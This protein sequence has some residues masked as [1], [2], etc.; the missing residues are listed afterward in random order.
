MQ[1]S[2]RSTGS[3]NVSNLV[4]RQVAAGRGEVPAIV[5]EDAALSYD[6]LR[7]Q[8]N[9]AGNLLRELGVHR[10]QRVLLILDDTSVFPT[11]FLGAIRIGAVPIPVSHLDKD[12]N[13]RH[14]I[15]DSYAEV[16]VTDAPLLERVRGA[17]GDRKV[18]WLATGGEGAGVIELGAALAAQSD[19]LDP[20]T[21]HPDDMAFWL[22][23][24]GSTGKPKGVVH[25]QHDVQVTCENYAQGVLGLR[26]DDVTFSTTKLFHAYGLGNGLSFPLSVGATAVYMAG[27]TKPAPIL[28]VLRRHRPSVLY[29]VPALFAAVGR[30]EIGRAHV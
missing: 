21:T 10:E 18:Q 24:S 20:V 3:Y 19:E 15:E 8:V 30:E 12:E 2:A 22:Y 7:R 29:S 4:E 13:F 1:H 17:L 27:P 28:E 25:L 26:P 5:A 9:R 23:S 11:V 16:V 6:E 14:F